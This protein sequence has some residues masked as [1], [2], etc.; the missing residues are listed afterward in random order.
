MSEISPQTENSTELDDETQSANGETLDSE[1]SVVPSCPSPFHEMHIGLRHSEARG[2]GYQS[3][4]TTLEGFGIYDRNRSFMPFIDLRGHVFDNGKLAGNIGVGGR[5]LL[6]SIEHLLGYYFYYDIRQD[7]HHLTAQQVSPGIELLGERME[8]RMNGYFPVGDRKSHKYRFKFDEFDG[9]HIFIKGKQRY[10]MIGADAEVGAHITQSRKYDLYAGVGPYYFSSPHASSWGGKA[11]LLGRYKEYVSLE[12]TYSYDHL[13]KSVIQGSVAI[14]LPFGRKLKQKGKECPKENDLVLSRAAFAPYRFEIPV[15]KKV[16]RKEKAINP[17]TGDPWKVWFV[18]NTS[19]SSGTFESPFPTLLDAQNASGPNDMIY[20]FPGNGTTMGM[21]MGFIL[22][23]GQKFF[24]SGISHHIHTTKGKIK[25]PPFSNSYPVITNTVDVVTLAN[26]NEISGLHIVANQIAASG[27]IGTPNGIFGSSGIA[28]TTIANNI[29]SCTAFATSGITING[30][31]IKIINN[32]IIST[33]V[34][35]DGILFITDNVPSTSVNIS[36]NTIS[37]YNFGILSLSLA[38]TSI[39]A[40][41]IISGNSISA[42]SR[43]G[44]FIDATSYASG[45]VNI[46]EN[47]IKNTISTTSSGG[48]SVNGGNSPNS[49]FVFIDNNNITTTSSSPNTFG[50]SL[51]NSVMNS[52]FNAD[53]SNN[54][55]LTGAGVGSIGIIVETGTPSAVICATISDNTVT[56]QVASGTNDFLISGNVNIDNFSGNIGSNIFT[57]GD[58]NLVPEGTC[59]E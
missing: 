5:T 59:G 11:R 25:I 29:I 45:I 31:D 36:N 41:I 21:D 33:S 27:I 3:G 28:G 51:S 53:I 7:R 37:G 18:N 56:E 24:G 30:H 47:V 49:A 1:R 58:V 46:S 35:V 57:T 22:Q 54:T 48:I 10:A 34:G 26:G 40:N 43:A 4:Y 16:S 13:F 52:I 44:I 15:I 32:Q 50:I 14:N 8:Y 19:S 23:N 39:N 2:V 6:S 55:I 38:S 9:N 42:C 20:V 17:A 12:A